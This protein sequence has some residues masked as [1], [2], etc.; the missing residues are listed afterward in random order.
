MRFGAGL[1]SQPTKLAQAIALRKQLGSINYITNCWPVAADGGDKLESVTLR[2]GTRTLKIP[3]D[4]LACGFHLVPNVE[5]PTLLGCELSGGFVR[6][7]DSQQT[8]VRDI[9]CA[10]EPTGIGGL[11]LAVVEGQIAGYA[12][13]GVPTNSVRLR[14]ERASFSK[15]QSRLEKAFALSPELRSIAA[16]DTLV[17]RCEDV[18][19][20]RLKEHNS[21]RSAKL[22]T[23]CG[24]GPCQGRVCGPAVEF[25]LGW[26][27]DSVRPPIFS[28]RVESLAH[29]SIQQPDNQN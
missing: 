22:H 8:S 25:L 18:S 20:G 9:Y 23:R 1:L 11:D 19:L 15:F 26:G 16:D 29:A 27:A 21:W 28:V 4:Y 5:L 17:C 2:S 3:C 14:S 7:D 24:M 6:V 13:A 12:A 10:G